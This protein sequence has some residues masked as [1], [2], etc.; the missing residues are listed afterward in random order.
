MVCC[1]C[2]VVALFNAVAKAKRDAA[3]T[4]KSEKLKKKAQLK[5]A[6][7]TVGLSITNND[8]HSVGS[9]GSL[10]IDSFL[11]NT[12]TSLLKKRSLRDAENA[13]DTKKKRSNDESAAKNSAAETTTATIKNKGWKVISDNLE[14]DVSLDWDKEDI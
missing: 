4:V 5:A 9:G 13:K 2:L 6:G 11:K 8:D 12:E 10:S 7:A 3:D 1:V 14:E